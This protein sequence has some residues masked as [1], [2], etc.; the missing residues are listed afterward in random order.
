MQ[1]KIIKCGG[2]CCDG[3]QWN[4]C[5]YMKEQTITE[6]LWAGEYIT[7]KLSPICTMFG[8]TEL[9]QGASL[10]VCNTVY[11]GSYEGNP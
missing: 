3:A 8:N 10:K 5:S 1:N 4:F 9:D 2:Y 7:Y 11:G 6:E